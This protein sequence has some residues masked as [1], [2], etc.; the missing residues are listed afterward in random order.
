MT[1]LVPPYL[2]PIGRALISVSDKSG[3]I[4][5]A[6]GLSAISTPEKRRFEQLLIDGRLK[7][8]SFDVRFHL[9]P[10]VTVGLDLGGTAVSL[11]LKSGEVWVFRHDGTATLAVDP[12]IY[13]EK[14][15]IRPR[16]ARQ[17]VLS[18]RALDFETQ[19]GWTLA[20]AQDTPLAIR[21]LVRED[22]TARI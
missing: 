16:P 2:I 11:A 4:D 12:S 10:D 21:D 19:V 14:A 8:V 3:L 1:N 18:A 5:L 7:G 17:I 6:R 13:L 9:H 15:R 22:V 20:K